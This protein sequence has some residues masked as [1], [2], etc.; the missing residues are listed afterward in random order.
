[1]VIGESQGRD[2]QRGKHIASG[3]E[4]LSGR[5]ASSFYLRNGL[6]EN[7]FGLSFGPFCQLLPEFELKAL[8]QLCELA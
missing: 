1:M 8:N 7:L 4:T 5:V 3:D 2:V 6:S